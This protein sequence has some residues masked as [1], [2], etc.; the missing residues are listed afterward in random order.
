MS[1]EKNQRYGLPTAPADPNQ[2]YMN[3]QETAYVLG[4]SV[5]TIRRRIATLNI[6]SK[7]GRR[8]M[9]SKRDRQRI[10]EHGR[11]VAKEQDRVRSLRAAR[12]AELPAA[13]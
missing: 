7:T 6:K 4:C 11:K 3:V 2:E 5:K 10:H 8:V 1:R 13:A 12:D 9:T